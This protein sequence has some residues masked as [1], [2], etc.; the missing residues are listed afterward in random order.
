MWEEGTVSMEMMILIYTKSVYFKLT[1]TVISEALHV[2]ISGL[3]EQEL[4][5]LIAPAWKS[6]PCIKYFIVAFSIETGMDTFV[7]PP[8]IFFL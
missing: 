6:P 2:T 4:I 5:Q 1:L 8:S 3:K 7:V